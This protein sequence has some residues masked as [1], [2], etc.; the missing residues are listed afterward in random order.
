MQ[1][2]SSAI[3]P[4]AFAKVEATLKEEIAAGN[5]ITTSVKPSI[6]SALGTVPKTD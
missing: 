5:Y 3:S 4:V 6:I 1:N 2:Y